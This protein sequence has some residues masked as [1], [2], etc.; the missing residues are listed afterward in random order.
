MTRFTF[1]LFGSGS[2]AEASSV[3]AKAPAGSRVEIKGPKRTNDQN[4]LMWVL[5]TKLSLTLPWDG[6]LRSPDKWKELFTDGLRAA[7]EDEQETLPAI[8]GSGRRVPVGNS[9]SDLSVEEMTMLI[10]LIYQ[11]GATH[12]VAFDD[13][14]D[15]A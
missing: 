6:R 4:N 13:E 10:E 14:R 1:T 12:G 8:D 7:Q 5:L 15:A 11:F 3:I 9:T 2:R